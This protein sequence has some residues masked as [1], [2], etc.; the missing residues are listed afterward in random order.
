M[1]YSSNPYPYRQQPAPVPAAPRQDP[2]VRARRSLFFT[3][4]V[5]GLGFLGYLLMSLLFGVVLQSSQRL[6]DMYTNQ[7]FYTY[8]LEIIY[9]YMCVGLPFL[10]VY[11]IL[12]RTRVHKDT[13]LPYGRPYSAGEAAALV[14]AAL[15]VCFL[16][17]I[18]ANYL[19]YY[20]DAAGFGF[21][22]YY[23][24][25]KP[26]ELPEGVSGVVVLT[27]RSALVPALMEEFAFRGVILQT[28]RK[29]GDWFAIVCS[30][31][32]FGAVHGNLTQLPF[33]I[34]AGL[35]LGYCAV[36]TGSL[37][38][39]IVVHFL[40][41][42][43]SVI[44]AVVSA[45]AGDGAGAVVSNF[46]V[47]AVIAV[48]VVVAVAYLVRKPNALRLRPCGVPGVRGKGRALFLAPVLL[49]ALI[50]LGWYAI[51]DIQP[52]AEWFGRLLS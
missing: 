12:K 10:F 50:W 49:A 8:L 5:L 11:L 30:A 34:V 48:G 1:E 25:L 26:E 35:A 14:P 40:N 19:A 52:V 21:V 45:R 33:A 22:S 31:V 51:N 41:N 6:Y 2:A 16:G 36:V 23:E 42:F 38:T 24:A 39:G 18:A 17:S 3:G 44:V 32:L 15:A 47:Y 9:S 7:P 37:R 46:I 43:V 27:L 4:N 29:Y 20:A 28:L 13:V